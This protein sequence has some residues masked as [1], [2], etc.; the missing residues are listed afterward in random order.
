MSDKEPLDSDISRCPN[1]DNK[2][3][4]VLV[5]NELIKKK[6]VL[7]I[8]A[9]SDHSYTHLCRKCYVIPAREA[10][11][12]FDK[13]EAKVHAKLLDYKIA[14]PVFT[15]HDIKDWVYEPLRMVTVYVTVNIVPTNQGKRKTLEQYMKDAE[16]LCYE[17]LKSKVYQSGGNA[18]LGA[19]I[20]YQQ[21]RAAFIAILSGTIV[22]VKDLPY[23]SDQY[24]AMQINKYELDKQL[25]Q[26]EQH[27]NSAKKLKRLLKDDDQLYLK[28]N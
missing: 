19:S 16:S 11:A 14:I 2:V 26:L 8:N 25:A 5:S 22:D 21:R 3:K 4:G 20:H 23:K 15:L 7:M 24:M 27:S 6:R 9:F 28:V 17:K 18:C 1:C 12:K 13:L 10:L